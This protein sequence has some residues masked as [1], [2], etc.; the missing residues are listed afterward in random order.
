VSSH[1]Q[2]P[3]GLGSPFSRVSEQHSS[4]IETS[5]SSDAVREP[6]AG[7][8]PHPVT[9]EVSI[10]TKFCIFITDVLDI[11]NVTIFFGNPAKS[12]SGQISSEILRMSVQLQYVQLITNS[13]Y[14]LISVTWTI[15][16]QN[17]LPFQNFVKNWQTVT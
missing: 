10:V 17:S 3:G 7:R 15:T 4:L 9:S 13:A 5:S 8:L 1:F 12:S 16:M 14:F 6:D 2:F 11:R